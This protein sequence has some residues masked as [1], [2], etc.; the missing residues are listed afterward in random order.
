MGRVTQGLPSRSSSAAGGGRG[1]C[2]RRPRRAGHGGG[3]RRRR[4]LRRDRDRGVPVPARGSGAS[5]LPPL[6]GDPGAVRLLAERLT[7]SAQRL[8][9][10]AAVLARLRDW[11][12]VGWAGRRRLRRTPARGA[13]GAGCRGASAS[14]VRAGPLRSLA[15]AMEEA[16]AVVG[17]A[18]RED[19]DAE[20]A[21][22]VL[23]D[24]AF[25][26]VCAGS[27]EESPDL[28]LVRPTSSATRSRSG[29]SRTARHAA[30]LERF[31]ETDRR[32]APALAA[33]SVDGVARLAAL[34]DPREGELG[35]ARPRE[36]LG[37]RWR[38]PFR[39]SVRS[40]RWVRGWAW[41][42]TRGAP[43]RVP[44]GGCRGTRRGS[45]ARG[46]TSTSTASGPGNR[47]AVN[48]GGIE[49][50]D[51][52]GATR[53]SVPASGTAPRTVDASLTVLDSL[54]RPVS[55]RGAYL[56]YVGSGRARR[57]HAGARARVDRSGRDRVRAAAP[58]EAAPARAR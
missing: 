51:V 54:D 35:P 9:A 33:L 18:V 10:L 25:A 39:G 20:H 17:A 30:A 23:E 57:A 13:A 19:A 4:G 46:S 37:A 6:P 26:L 27:G 28:L 58:A 49:H 31:R 22:A 11:G 1:T 12:D 45:C 32:C 50:H 53:S 3:G 21:Y 55:R 36:P 7:S 42:P 24:R 16:Q 43:P 34:P 38:R 47:V 14:A 5:A 52:G 44:G 41:A 2:W 8:A 56:T 15:D 48:L 40:P 29:P